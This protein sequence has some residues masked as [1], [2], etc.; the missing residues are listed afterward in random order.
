MQAHCAT[1]NEFCD[2]FV[3]TTGLSRATTLNRMHGLTQRLTAQINQ[4]DLNV[5][6][7]GL[8]KRLLTQVNQPDYKSKYS[9][10]QSAGRMCVHSQKSD[11]ADTVQERERA[12]Q[13]GASFFAGRKHGARGKRARIQ[14]KRAVESALGSSIY[15]TDSLLNTH[16]TKEAANQTASL[17]YVCLLMLAVS[18]MA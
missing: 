18:D 13:A 6:N 2:G 15:L 16:I 10:A 7:G 5:K 11:L 17:L 14:P 8:A 1:S 9:N 12:R 4:P 3:S